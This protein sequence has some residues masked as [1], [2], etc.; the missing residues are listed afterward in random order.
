[1]TIVFKGLAPHDL[2]PARSISVQS[3]NRNVEVTLYV[4]D[5][6][7]PSTSIPIRIQMTPVIA[8]SL[9]ERLMAVAAEVESPV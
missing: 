5:D 7:H 8:R 2:A 6:W 3:L 1:M 9:A 4:P